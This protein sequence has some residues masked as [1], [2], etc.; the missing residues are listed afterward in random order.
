MQSHGHL[1]VI[2]YQRAIEYNIELCQKAKLL[3][4]QTELIGP[5][6]SRIEP[7]VTDLHDTNGDVADFLATWRDIY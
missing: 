3:V 5:F 7:Y 2:G 1:D 4:Q 6:V